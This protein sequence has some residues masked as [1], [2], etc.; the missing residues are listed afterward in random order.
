VVRD[1]DM[2]VRIAIPDSPEVTVFFLYR[3]LHEWRRVRVWILKCQGR[4]RV[5]FLIA[6]HGLAL[7]EPRAKPVPQPRFAKTIHQL[8]LDEEVE[9]LTLHF[10]GRG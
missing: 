1:T 3:S 7:D 5:V 6:V 4:R 8:A 2:S 9:N 10:F